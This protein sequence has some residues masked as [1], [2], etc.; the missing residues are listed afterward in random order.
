MDG[1]NKYPCLARHQDLGDAL[2]QFDKRSS[3]GSSAGCISVTLWSPLHSPKFEHY[4]LPVTQSTSTRASL[5]GDAMIQTVSGDKSNLWIA[6]YEIQDS[7][8]KEATR[9]GLKCCTR[10]KFAQDEASTRYALH[11]STLNL[12]GRLILQPI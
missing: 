1:D 11:P 5:T 9:F 2:P 3:G 12:F 6:A 8:I 10:N 4:L 7:S